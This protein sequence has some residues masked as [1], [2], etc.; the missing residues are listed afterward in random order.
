M[1]TLNMLVKT[2]QTMK[3]VEDNTVT[4][5]KNIGIVIDKWKGFLKNANE[6]QDAFNATAACFTCLI[7]NVQRFIEAEM[8][9][10]NENKKDCLSDLTSD[11]KENE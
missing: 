2:V 10:I 7:E 4:L 8:N 6:T 1:N 11:C 9:L 3:A 5:H